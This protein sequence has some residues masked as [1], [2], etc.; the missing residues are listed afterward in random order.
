MKRITLSNLLPNVFQ[1]GRVI[2]S[3]VWN[4][5]VTLDQ[6]K[7]YLIEAAS[8]TGKSSL[9]SFLY[10]YRVDFSGRILFDERASS[11]LSIKEWTRLRQAEFAILFQELRLFPELTA[12]E[13]IH[14]KN[15][16][17][18]YKT[19]QEI[20]TYFEALGIGEKKHQLCGKLS[21]GQRQRVAFIRTLC[22][23]CAFLFLDEPISHL[24]RENG[25]IMK[26]LLLE[27]LNRQGAGLILTSIGKHL[28][29]PYHTHLTL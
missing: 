22:Q 15:Q 4:S 6:G 17:T 20:E 26:A 21:W 7:H 25:E 1:D 27:E 5:E 10:G 3:E 19:E 13:N 2:N 18:G 12:L 8:G 11:T 29:M 9:L 24:D 28:D 23:P 16:L 14:I